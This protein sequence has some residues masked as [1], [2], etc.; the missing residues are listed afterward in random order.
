MTKDLNRKISSIQYNSLNL[1]T[2]ISEDM[3]IAYD[4]NSDGAKM[5]AKHKTS[6]VPTDPFPGTLVP[7]G[8]QGVFPQGGVIQGVIE[9]RPTGP[10]T[11]DSLEYR[12][13]FVYHNGICYQNSGESFGGS[14]EFS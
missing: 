14:P 1:L 2:K 6:N 5:K 8:G 13:S 9:P 7:M 10:Y 3:E 11:Y 4:Y 12:G